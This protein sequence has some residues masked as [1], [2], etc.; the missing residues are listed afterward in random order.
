MSLIT[1]AETRHRLR[2]ESSF[3]L[4]L[5]KI[6]H[7]MTI[8]RNF[9][10][11]GQCLANKISAPI[12]ITL[13]R[14]ANVCKSVWGEGRVRVLCVRV[15]V[16]VSGTVRSVKDGNMCKCLRAWCLVCDGVCV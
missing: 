1:L 5:L 16:G 4:N 9:R 3:D 14:N 2:L 12:K 8:W 10:A 11:H 15:N 13:D 6:K 7:L